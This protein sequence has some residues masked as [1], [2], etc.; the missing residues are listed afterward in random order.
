MT[1][2]E[3][4]VERQRSQLAASVTL[5]IQSYFD[6]LDAVAAAQ[7]VE[8]TYSQ[9]VDA[10]GEI[11]DGMKTR[12]INNVLIKSNT[13]EEFAQEIGCIYKA[14]KNAIAQP[15]QPQRVPLTDREMH[16]ALE[17]VCADGSALSFEVMQKDADYINYFV[18]IARAIEA[19]HG[20][21][22]ASEGGA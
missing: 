21:K 11:I 10:L 2:D 19:A 16:K 6:L 20:I 3:I 17:S 1:K 9:Q 14:L 8:P 18:P 15:V 7:P 13:L 22:P 5:P 4:A 12:A